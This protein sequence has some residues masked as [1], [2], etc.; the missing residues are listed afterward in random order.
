[1]SLLNTKHV[2]ISQDH[3]IVHYPLLGDI[4]IE[5]QGDLEIDK[6]TEIDRRK[7][8]KFGQ[9]DFNLSL[10]DNQISQ[11]CEEL[12]ITKEE[13]DVDKMAQLS[14]PLKD[15]ICNGNNKKEVV[16]FIGT[17]QRLIGKL[18]K[19]PSPLAIMKFDQDKNVKIEKIIKYKFQFVD[20]PLPIM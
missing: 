6:P 1:M 8:Y 19:L 15:D 17:K 5:I 7:A 20:R 11:I 18:L 9:L 14:Q 13:I 2:D 12:Q 16:L 3:D 4:I 10:N